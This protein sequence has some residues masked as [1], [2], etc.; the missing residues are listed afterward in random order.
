MSLSLS[1]TPDFQRQMDI[2]SPQE[3]LGTSVT[4]IGAGG[5]GSPTAM[6][7]AK[8]GVPEL[9]IYDHDSVEAHNLPNQLMYRPGDIGRTKVSALKQAVLEYAPDTTVTVVPQKFDGTTRLS[10]IVVSGVDSMAARQ[11]VWKSVKGNRQVR[12]YIEG[13]T[14][15][16]FLRLYA[17]DPN[18]RSKYPWYEELLYPDAGAFQAACTARSIIYTS[19]IMGGLIARAVKMHIKR[20]ESPKEVMFD[21]QNLTL[22]VQ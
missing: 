17:F 8:M 10:G 4:L 20:Q 14:G 5:I 13:R 1:R 6:F 3:L 12:F 19:A 22:V 21:L 9:I 15:A 16:E 11:V 7:L 2:L 18:D